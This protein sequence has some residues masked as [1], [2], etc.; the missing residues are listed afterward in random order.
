MGVS[1]PRSQVG[2]T[3]ILLVLGEKREKENDENWSEV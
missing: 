3:F 1:T 2:I